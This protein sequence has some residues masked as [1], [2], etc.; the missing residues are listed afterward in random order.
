MTFTDLWRRANCPKHDHP[1]SVGSARTRGTTLHSSE[2][3]PT[4]CH[5]PAWQ[6]GN[7][8][9]EKGV[10][11]LCQAPI[12]FCFLRGSFTIPKLSVSPQNSNSACKAINKNKFNFSRERCVLHIITWSSEQPFWGRAEKTLLLAVPGRAAAEV[13]SALT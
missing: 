12:R 13:V 7:T 3:L 11:E 10:A 8:G 5:L 1:P 9:T 6:S 2:L 4:Q